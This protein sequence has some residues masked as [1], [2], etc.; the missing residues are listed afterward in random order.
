MDSCKTHVV[1]GNVAAWSLRQALQLAGRDEEVLAFQDDLS[2]GPIATDASE[3]R[4]KWWQQI[5]RM[6]DPSVADQRLWQ[7]VL[8]ND[9]SWVIWFGR[10]F[11]PDLAFFMAWAERLDN[12]AYEI[13]DVTGYH[14]VFTRNDGSTFSWPP[15]QGVVSLPPDGLLTFLGQETPISTDERAQAS[16]AWRR[17]KSENAAFRVLSA[18]GFVSA[19]EDYF[20]GSMLSHLSDSWVSVTRMIGNI[21]DAMNPYI[22]GGGDDVLLSRLL[23]L[24]KNG[25]IMI[26]GRLENISSCYVRLTS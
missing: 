8:I 16:A 10:H 15:A 6:D 4:M 24:S 12:R 18:G 2:C 14:Y 7:R 11:A 23:V 5:G 21:W 26:R 25:K 22:Q 19:G 1:C 3:A 13:V 9:E 17:L 20:D